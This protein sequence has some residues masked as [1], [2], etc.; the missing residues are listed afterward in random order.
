MHICM[1]THPTYH[2]RFW[3]AEVRGERTEYTVEERGLRTSFFIFVCPARPDRSRPAGAGRYAVFPFVTPTHPP[4]PPS[5]RRKGFG[6]FQVYPSPACFPAQSVRRRCYLGRRVFLPGGFPTAKEGV[7][8]RRL[9]QRRPE[10]PFVFQNPTQV[11]ARKEWAFFLPQM[12]N[13]F[14]QVVLGSTPHPPLRFCLQSHHTLQKAKL[15]SGD[16]G[17]ICVKPNRKRFVVLDKKAEWWYTKTI[18]LL[19]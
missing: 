3:C 18:R 17:Q 8:F 13:T 7:V 9:F 15:P 19:R 4:L 1:R 5:V 11:Q 14:R 16:I 2:N 6:H 12:R 10:G